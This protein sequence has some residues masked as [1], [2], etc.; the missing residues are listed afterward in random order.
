MGDF[1]AKLQIQFALHNEKNKQKFQIVKTFT[2]HDKH[3]DFGGRGVNKN[4][5]VG[6]ALF[7]SLGYNIFGA[8]QET[9]NH[10]GV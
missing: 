1:E 8:L 6:W 9:N 3:F 10:N 2:G 7:Q 5:K 4:N